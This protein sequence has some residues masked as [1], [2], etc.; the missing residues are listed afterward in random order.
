M[1]FEEV[2]KEVIKECFYNTITWH[3]DGTLV[4]DEESVSN[5]SDVIF[6]SVKDAAFMVDGILAS[7]YQWII[8]RAK[9]AGIDVN[10][11]LSKSYTLRLHLVKND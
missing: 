6:E 5:L 11:F 4:L 3:D 8:K 10:S 9:L 7:D 1:T 2:L